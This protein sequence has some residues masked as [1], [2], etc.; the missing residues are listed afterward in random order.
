MIQHK[1][2]LHDLHAH[3]YQVT[4]TIPKPAP[5]QALAMAVWIPG[6]YLVREFSKH[7]QALSAKQDGKKLAIAQL[8]KNT[9]RL[10]NTSAK[11]VTVT[12][13]VYAFDASVR[14]AFLDSTRG[15]FNG[16]SLFMRVAGQEHAPQQVLIEPARAISSARTEPVEVLSTWRVATALPALQINTAGFG[17]YQASHYDE[18]ADSPFELGD[19]WQGK[20]TARGVKHH[21]VVSGATATFDGK[22]LLADTQK[23]VERELAFWHGKNGKPPQALL[24]KGYVFMLR[25]THDGYGGL[26]HMNS[27]ALIAKRSDLPRINDSSTPEG[28]ITLLGLI[29]HEYFHTWNVKRL[30]PANLV[31]YDYDRENYTELLWFFEG[32][33]SYYD[34]LILRRAGLMSDAQYLNLLAKTINRV[35]QTPGRLVHPLASSSFEAWTKYYRM[36]ENSVNSTVSYYTRGALVALCLDLS[37]RERGSN[38]DAVM[39]ALWQ[40]YALPAKSNTAGITEASILEAIPDKAC[41]QA[42][43]RWVH[44][45]KDLPLTKLLATAGV[46]TVAVKANLAQQ[47]GLRVGFEGGSITIKQVLSGTPAHTAGFAAGDEWLALEVESKTGHQTWRISSMDDVALYAPAGKPI[48]AWVARDKQMLTLTLTLPKN[49]LLHADVKL[50]IADAKKLANWLG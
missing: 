44:T 14:T 34:D 36:D 17:T 37:L 7:V 42:L 50:K 26:E 15:F 8:D 29:S 28:Y 49:Q 12:Y 18:L 46:D 24:D 6:S 19:F 30:R 27:T 48:T 4:L 5:H 35:M 1:V 2:Q 31:P 40:K 41:G 47:L 43:L 23:I 45:T 3:L 21:F 13:Q 9:W 38:L 11:P 25:A 39:Q 10:A 33:T 22:R 16:T 32:F 20:F